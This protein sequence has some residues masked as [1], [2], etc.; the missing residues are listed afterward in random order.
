M[1]LLPV[2]YSFIEVVADLILST[3]VYSILKKMSSSFGIQ[4]SIVISSPQSHSVNYHQMTENSN[5]SSQESLSNYTINTTI[6]T[7]NQ[8]ERIVK[9]DNLFEKLIRKP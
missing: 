8:Q 1:F 9:S 3:S 7:E 2:L 6:N 5:Y 4:P